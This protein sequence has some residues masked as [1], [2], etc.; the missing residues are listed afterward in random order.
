MDIEI[1][2]RIRTRRLELGMTQEKLAESLGVT[3]QMCQGWE[4]GTKRVS[5]NRIADIAKSLMVDANYLLDIE[6]I[7]V[8]NYNDKKSIQLVKNFRML[9]DVLQKVL[10]NVSEQLKNVH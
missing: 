4:T 6:N 7:E 10:L 9:S 2:R 8:T 1:G 5:V 3:Y